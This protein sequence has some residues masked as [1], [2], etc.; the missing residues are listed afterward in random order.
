MEYK[1]Y[2]IT[3]KMKITQEVWN[4]FLNIL[5][6]KNISIPKVSYMD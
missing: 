1:K 5:N 3:G 2:N 4:D 6:E